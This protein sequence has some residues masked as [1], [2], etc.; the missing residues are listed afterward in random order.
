MET[1]NSIQERYAKLKEQRFRGLIRNLILVSLL[2]TAMAVGFTWLEMRN[3]FFF[4]SLA[5][6]PGVASIM[7]DRKP[8]RFASKSVFAFN[9]TGAFPYFLAIFLS[10]NADTTAQNSIQDPMAWILIYGFSAFGWGVIYIIPRI[11]LIVIEL[12]SK[13]TLAKM[14]KLQSELV[15]EWGEEIKR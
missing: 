6:L 2:F 4:V 13:L 8:G 10:G 14:E 7:W 15:E 5:F 9:L 1:A 11:T 12:R 3:V